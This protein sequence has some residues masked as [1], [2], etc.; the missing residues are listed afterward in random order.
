M[1]GEDWDVIGTQKPKSSGET[2]DHHMETCMLTGGNLANMNIDG[3]SVLTNANGVY[4]VNPE[5]GDSGSI[6][7]SEIMRELG[8]EGHETD[9]EG[10]F[11]IA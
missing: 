9:K 3:V 8:G 4:E 2:K 10:G 1:Q 5:I 11:F 7:D 6:Q